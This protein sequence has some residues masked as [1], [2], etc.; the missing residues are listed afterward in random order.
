M[1]KTIKGDITTL[2]VDAIVNAANNSLLGGGGVDGAIHRAAGSG[3]LDECKELGGCPTGE[4]RITKAYNLPSKFVIHAVG[5]VWQN[6]NSN[7]EELLRLA[8]KNS[9]ELAQ[10]NNCK[11]IAFP[12]ISTGAYNF[13]KRDAA[14]IAIQTCQQF[15]DEQ[16]S[17][18]LIIFV[19]F[20]E[21]NY[22]IYKELCPNF[23]S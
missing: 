23:N 19:C 13:P 2:H 5:P 18:M 16:N 12:N 14:E 20:D 15:L 9:L 10:K 8:Y 17:D 22:M 3:L 21:I 6:G 11:S 7:E 4:A 1:R